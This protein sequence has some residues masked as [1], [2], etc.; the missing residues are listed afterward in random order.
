MLQ[1]KMRSYKE[2]NINEV[3]M[4]RTQ[5][6]DKL[7]NSPLHESSTTSLWQCHPSGAAAGPLIY[8]VSGNSS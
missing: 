3:K 4:L 2:E 1:C 7:H 8:N 6:N 5:T